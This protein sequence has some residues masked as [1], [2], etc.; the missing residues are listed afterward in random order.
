MAIRTEKGLKYL[1][2]HLLPK[3]SVGNIRKATRSRGLRRRDIWVDRFFISSISHL[4]THTDCFGS[5]AA[6]QLLQNVLPVL[7]TSQYR[8]TRLNRRKVI[9]LENLTRRDIFQLSDLAQAPVGHHT[10]TK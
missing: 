1:L 10:A 4:D 6:T 7:S 3:G 2:N 9:S 8:D 5:L